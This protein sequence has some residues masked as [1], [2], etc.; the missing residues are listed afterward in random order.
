[1]AVRVGAPSSRSASF[2]LV[3]LGKAAVGKSSLVVR[4]TKNEFAEFQES[5]IG[6]AF[7]TQTV[8][9]SD[10][11]NVKFEIWDT[12]GQERYESLAPMYYRG[13]HAALVVYD[14]TALE[15]FEKAKKWIRDLNRQA[16]AGIV[17]CLVGNKVDKTPRAVDTEMA[18]KYAEEIDVLFFETSARTGANVLEAF[19]AVAERLPRP[20][21]AGG[22]GPAAPGEPAPGGGKTCCAIM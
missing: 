11:A 13:A 3:L 12:A 2:K 21:T 16:N 4:F 17:V 10:G 1:M 8:S 22:A 18:R 14:V 15:S 6:A 9:L 19:R 5:T 20:A 7:C